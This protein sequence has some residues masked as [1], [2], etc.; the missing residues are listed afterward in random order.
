MAQRIAFDPLL[1][2]SL[3]SDLRKISLPAY[4]DFFYLLYYPQ[5]FGR[6]GIVMVLDGKKDRY[7][8]SMKLRVTYYR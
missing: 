6:A 3:F 4:P 1:S 2:L 5:P 8:P 7:R